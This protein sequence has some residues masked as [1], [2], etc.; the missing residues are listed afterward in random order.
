[1]R[2]RRDKRVRSLPKG[3]LAGF[4][5]GIVGAGVI[6]V[7]EEMLS[8]PQQ[9]EPLPVSLLPGSAQPASPAEAAP[10]GPQA[11]HWA[12]GA[13]AGGLYGMAAEMEPTLSAWGGA[14]FG[15]TLNRMTNESLL[16]RMGLTT[17]KE[18]Q[19]TQTRVSQWISHAAYGIATDAVRRLVRRLL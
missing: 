19:S 10:A 11:M 6:L 17:S 15:I 2:T 8:P 5:G 1:M 12:V 18:E 7:A 3:F 13:L 16:P 9:R 4:V 14:A